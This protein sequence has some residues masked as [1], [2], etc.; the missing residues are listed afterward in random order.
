MADANEK[1]SDRTV[2]AD[3]IERKALRFISQHTEKPS[4]R[5]WFTIVPTTPHHG[6]NIKA[7]AQLVTIA[8]QIPSVTDM[9]HSSSGCRH[10]P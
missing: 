4:D 7:P 10:D 9:I 6:E 2:S 8:F 3:V 5:L 1:H